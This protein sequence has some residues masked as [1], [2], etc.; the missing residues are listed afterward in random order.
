VLVLS[1]AAVTSEHVVGQCPFRF[2]LPIPCQV[3][4]LLGR[5]WINGVSC[6]FTIKPLLD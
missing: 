6:M 1:Y 4:F 5:S 3:T 2:G